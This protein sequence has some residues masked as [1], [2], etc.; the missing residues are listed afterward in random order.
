MSNILRFKYLTAA[1]LAFLAV[2][3]LDAQEK[4][5]PS[6]KPTFGAV[7]LDAGFAPAPHSVE[8]QAGGPIRTNLGGVNSHVA[9]APDFSLQYT[10]GQHPLTFFVKSVGDT[11]LLINLP[12][13]SWVADDDSG[14]GLDPLIRIAKPASGRYDIYVGTFQ[15][16]IV[17]ATL[18]ISDQGAAKKP[19][20]P[21]NASLPECFIISAGIDN[22]RT[23]NKLSGCL[24]DARNT[25]TAFQAQTGTVFRKVNE[26]ILLDEAASHG[27]ITKSFLGLKT[28]GAAGDYMVLFLSGHGARTNGNKGNTWFFLPVDFE[29]K[30]FTNTALTDKQIL[31]IGDQLVRQKKNVI[32][33]IDACFVGQLSVNAQ[34]FLQKYQ[35]T[36]QGGLALM[37]SSSPNQTSAA[38]GNYS[39]YAKAFADSMTAAGDLNKDTKITLGEIQTYSK[40]RTTDLLAAARTGSKQDAIITWSPS[41]SKETPL[42]H[43][44]EAQALVAVNKPLPKE[45]PKIFTGTETLPGYGKL[46]FALYTNGR[47]VMTDAKSTAEGLW[48]QQGD[49]YTL[50]FENGAVVYTGTLNGAALSGAATSPSAR[51]EGLKTWTWSVQRQPG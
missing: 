35:K 21:F 42:A 49:Q 2:G 6:L 18:H 8:V 14:G 43:A 7:K 30:Q 15:K 41:L 51:Q 20:P 40:K 29:P 22:Y 1:V 3:R 9:K 19:A 12:D 46:S 11:T 34:P 44:G 26:R 24:N 5:D 23:Q 37:L 48:R 28:Q 39:A 17:A 16:N 33:I 38:L 45:A 36:N 10:A 13:G 31:D 47:V 50:S 4:P 25:V 32:V 27:A